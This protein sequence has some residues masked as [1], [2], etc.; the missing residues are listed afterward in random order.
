MRRPLLGRIA[1]R[2]VPTWGTSCCALAARAKTTSCRNVSPKT[3]F[4]RDTGSVMQ[5]CQAM[6]FLPPLA[7]S[8]SRRIATRLSLPSMRSPPMHCMQVPQGMVICSPITRILTSGLKHLKRALPIKIARAKVIL[9]LLQRLHFC[10]R[11]NLVLIRRLSQ[12]DYL[13]VSR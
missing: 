11:L 1:I 5:T 3:L 2:L 8:G 6:G 7:G 12:V 13:Q 4:R 10:Q 9:T